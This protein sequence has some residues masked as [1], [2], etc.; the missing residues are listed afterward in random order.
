MASLI[1]ASG[2]SE[3]RR[4]FWRRFLGTPLAVLSVAWVVVVAAACIF[5]PMLTHQTGLL[6]EVAHSYAAPT[7]A[8]ILGTD[9]LGRDE[10][11]RVLIGGRISLLV[12][13]TA[14]L[15]AMLI[16][17][18]V[19][20]IAGFYG[21]AVDAILMRIVDVFLSV[22]TLFLL[23]F[24]AAMFHGSVVALIVVIGATS[25]LNPSRLVR[26]EI[27]TIKERLYIE[28]ARAL[29]AADARILLR[30]VIP[31]TAGTII[32]TSTFMIANAM[33]AETALSYLGIGVRAPTP[34]WGNLLSSAQSD[35]F[36]GAYWLILPAGLAIL[37]TVTAL[38]FIGDWLREHAAQ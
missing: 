33:L 11:V 32:T 9:G 28:A 3:G 16:G 22:P 38:N 18:A 12:G 7:E 25:W 36:A 27:L 6:T 35:V 20:A 13:L 4:R 29:G 37:F 14:A 24:L 5:Y 8:H 31:N 2:T 34:S 23:L 26:G 15:V 30:H 10:F 1:L 19:G 21:G 17:T